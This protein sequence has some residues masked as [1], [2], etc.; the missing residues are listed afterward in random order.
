MYIQTEKPIVLPLC[1]MAPNL[2]WSFMFFMDGPT[3]SRGIFVLFSETYGLK[4][5]GQNIKF[6]HLAKS[7]V[8]RMVLRKTHKKEDR[9]PFL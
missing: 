3:E 9:D 7:E 8:D 4:G 5:T 1:Q 6:H 2:S